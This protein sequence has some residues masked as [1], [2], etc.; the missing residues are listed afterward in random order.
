MTVAELDREIATYEKNREGLVGSA[1]DKYVL[2]HGDDIIGTYDTETDAV[3]E[4]YR[5]LGNVPF[6]VRHISPVD[7][8][9]NFLSGL[10]SL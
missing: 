10:V 9:V 7:R 1:L 6:L 8:P 5:R 2:I 4:G 3:N